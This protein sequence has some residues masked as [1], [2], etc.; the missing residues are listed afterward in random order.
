M[1]RGTIY[2]C[3]KCEL[4]LYPS[5][6]SK[7]S[8]LLMFVSSLY[9]AFKPCFNKSTAPYGVL[10]ILLR[11]I[12]ML[13]EIDNIPWNILHSNLNMENI[14]FNIVSLTMHCYEYE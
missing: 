4:I 9:Q 5:T 13:C 10:T 12:T 3:G 14:L 7:N 1:V 8:D 11:S 6:P 2:K